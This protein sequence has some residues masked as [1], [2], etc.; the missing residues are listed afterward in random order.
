[1]VAASRFVQG[2]IHHAFGRLG[3]LVLRDIEVVHG[4]LQ[5]ESH[6]GLSDSIR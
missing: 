3:H 4:R 2:A 5:R 1:M 6:S